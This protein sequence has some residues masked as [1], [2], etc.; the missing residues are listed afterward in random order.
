MTFPASFFCTALNDDALPPLDLASAATDAGLPVD[1]GLRAVAA[2]V[3]V[4]GGAADRARFVP[5][6]RLFCSQMGQL[7]RVRHATEKRNGT[8]A[9]C[10]RLIILLLKLFLPLIL[11]HMLNLVFIVIIVISIVVAFAVL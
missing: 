1:L 2:A 11:S 6:S 8:Y 7:K 5:G 9:F 3:A 4:G 10:W